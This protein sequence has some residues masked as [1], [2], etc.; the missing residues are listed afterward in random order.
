MRVRIR[1]ETWP[2]PGTGVDRHRSPTFVDLNREDTKNTKGQFTC[3]YDRL[4]RAGA[5]YTAA[6]TGAARPESRTMDADENARSALRVSTT[7]MPLS[8]TACQS[9]AE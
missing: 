5:G 4:E 7:G 9:N 8:T 6:G 1:Q 3:G 2:A